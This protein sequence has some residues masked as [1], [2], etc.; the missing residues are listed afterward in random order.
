[1]DILVGSQ[2]SISVFWCVMHVGEQLDA[3]LLD[4]LIV[5]LNDCLRLFLVSSDL[6]QVAWLL[7]W[8]PYDLFQFTEA[9][10]NRIHFNISSKK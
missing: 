7:S 5:T 3:R 1:M 10:A 4:C 6:L 2:C 8:V 9:P